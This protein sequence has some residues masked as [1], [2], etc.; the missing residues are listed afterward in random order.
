MNNGFKSSKLKVDGFVNIFWVHEQQNK[1]GRN[2]NSHTSGER[3]YEDVQQ[4]VIPTN[5]SID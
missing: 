1:C 3:F 4:A 5:Q 2:H